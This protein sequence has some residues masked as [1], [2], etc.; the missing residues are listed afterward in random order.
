MTQKGA[1]YLLGVVLLAF[2]AVGGIGAGTFAI[3][4]FVLPVLTYNI[5]RAIYRKGGFIDTG[6]IGPLYYLLIGVVALTRP[7]PFLSVATIALA[8]GVANVFSR[9]TEFRR[10][11]FA[12][13]MIILSI[14]PLWIGGALTYWEWTTA[15]RVY[16]GFFPKW[17][18]GTDAGNDFMW[19]FI[20]PGFCSL[21]IVPDHLL[22]TTEHGIIPGLGISVFTIWG[23]FLWIALIPAF[24]APVICGL[25]HAQEYHRFKLWHRWIFTGM[26]WICGVLLQFLVIAVTTFLVYISK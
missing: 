20:I 6:H 2:M 13:P 21:K 16:Y 9:Y 23:I 26:S 25:A 3:D 5:T 15:T 1:A 14:V 7:T 11:F 8:V 19:R 18:L 22:P 17:V 24:F 12:G 10:A 4:F